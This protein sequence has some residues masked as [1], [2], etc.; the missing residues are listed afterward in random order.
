MRLIETRSLARTC[1]LPYLLNES[2]PLLVG[3]RHGP[4]ANSANGPVCT[5]YPPEPFLPFLHPPIELA[6]VRPGGHFH[7]DWRVDFPAICF[8]QVLHLGV[9]EIHI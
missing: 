7:P 6:S 4:A 3:T 8:R 9:A 5:A 2:A 1:V